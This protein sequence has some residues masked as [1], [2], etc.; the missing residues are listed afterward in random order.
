MTG[1]AG[2]KKK[3]AINCRQSHMWDKTENN[4]RTISQKIK[5][6]RCHL[7][8]LASL[9]EPEPV[10]PKLFCGTGAG[11]IISYYYLLNK[12]FTIMLTVWRMPELKKNYF[13]PKLR[14]I[15]DD[16]TDTF[17]VQFLCC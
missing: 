3:K 4:Y 2:L 11:A 5:T 7:I 13:I 14:N 10:K 8:Y 1:P 15:S 17:L 16:I 9:A 12:Y 6:S